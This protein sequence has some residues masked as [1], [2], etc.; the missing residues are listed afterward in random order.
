MS[1]PT[2]AR[3]LITGP[4]KA[5]KSTFVASVGAELPVSPALTIR[6]REAA[7]PEAEAF[8]G[9]T[10]GIVLLVD[11]T[12]PATFPQVP[13]WVDELWAIRPLPL[14]IAVTKQDHSGVDGPLDV[15]AELPENTEIKVFPCICSDKT[16]CENVLLAL[17]YQMLSSGN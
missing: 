8:L 14:I 9:E 4:S 15:L 17:I 13:M 3:F 1:Q 12:Q 16:S 6:L 10:L 11:G 2:F 7:L 5:G